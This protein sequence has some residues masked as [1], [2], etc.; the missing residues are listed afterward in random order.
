MLPPKTPDTLKRTELRLARNAMMPT[1]L[2]RLIEA[3]SESGRNTPTMPPP[4]MGEEDGPKAPVSDEPFWVLVVDDDEDAR[5]IMQIILEAD[6]YE[7]TTERDGFRALLHLERRYF[8][9]QFER[10]HRLVP[11]VALIDW[12]M[13]VMDGFELYHQMRLKTPRYDA[14]ETVVVSAY[15]DDVIKRIPWVVSLGKP[16]DAKRL[17]EVVA[18]KARMHP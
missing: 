13:P 9:R 8:E 1:Q 14:V 7:V 3:V 15:T 12:M 5:E 10:R 2:R 6:G 18:Q 17:L 11:A 16:V 4:P